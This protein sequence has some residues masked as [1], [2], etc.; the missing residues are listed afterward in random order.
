[1]KFLMY[2]LINMGLLAIKINIFILFFSF[3]SCKSQEII[4]NK[5]NISYY[6][7]INEIISKDI[8]YN[9]KK[10]ELV[11][12]DP[13][14]TEE[15][16]NEI[17][18]RIPNEDS[19]IHLKQ[20]NIRLRNIIE[21]ELNR[22]TKYTPLLDFFGEKKLINILN[23]F[24][25]ENFLDINTFDKSIKIINS[26]L[27]HGHSFSSP[28]IIDNIMIVYHDKFSST[29]SAFSEVLIYDITS[30]IKPQIIMV[31]HVSIS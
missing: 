24:P 8:I 1:M 23:N 9:N 20:S 6:K 13:K 5:N 22:P 12:N 30:N 11:K 28:I 26:K 10:V 27:E 21:K 16:K 29:Y 3:Y 15:Q 7:I 31:V 4:N 18:N 25:K 19:Y 14:L 17:I 2:N